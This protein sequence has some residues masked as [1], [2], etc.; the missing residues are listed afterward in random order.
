VGVCSDRS[1]GPPLEHCSRKN[2]A[3]STSVFEKELIWSNARNGR[4]TAKRFDNEELLDPAAEE[5]GRP[6]HLGAFGKGKRVLNVDAKIAN[7]AL[8]LRVAE[9]DL[10]GAQIAG[11]LIY[12]GRLGSAQ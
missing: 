12:D 9:Q 8:D 3:C 10:H 6:L 4:T 11:L 2:H 5:L 7:G 1:S